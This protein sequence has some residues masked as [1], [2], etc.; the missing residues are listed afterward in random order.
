M[1]DLT[2]RREAGEGV[3]PVRVAALALIVVALVSTAL[4]RSW[5]TAQARALVVLVSVLDPPVISWTVEALTDEPRFAETAVAGTPTT[6]V[7]PGSGDGPWPAVLFVNGATPLGREHP[8]VRALAAGL[9]RSGFLVLVPD[10]PG[11]REGAITERTAAATVAVGRAATARLD[12]RA[13]R[14]ALLGVSVGASLALLAAEH[15]E[16]APRV[17]V[18]GGL[19]PYADL[20]QVVRLATTGRYR[21]QGRLVRYDVDPFVALAIGRSLVA[22]LPP[23]EARDELVALL[24]RVDDE[25]LDPLAAIR[26]T[27]PDTPSAEAVLRLLGNRDASRFDALFQQLPPELL[28]AVRRLSPLEGAARLEAPVELASPPRDKY[29]PLD[30]SRA[31]VRRAPD[32]R[33]TVTETL[34]HAIPEA[35]LGELAGL[36]RL[37][38]FA[39]RVL[40]RAAGGD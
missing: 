22:A 39:M 25:A 32:A 36:A 8:D 16:L 38:A 3:R 15:P 4:L 2:G 26:A 17:S 13:D 21:V 14:V 18:V 37:D 31:L 33:L 34:E 7:R 27:R 19:A 1:G 6:V 40:R 23:G 24:A 20:A 35:S 11:L 5:V 12:V 30:E 10:L 28:A 29:F 9:A